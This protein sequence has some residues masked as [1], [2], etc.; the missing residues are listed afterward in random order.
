MPDLAAALN[1]N[2]DVHFPKLAMFKFKQLS[3]AM[4]LVQCLSVL[5]CKNL[6]AVIRTC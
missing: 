1:V 3:R 2:L 6:S 4:P 5:C